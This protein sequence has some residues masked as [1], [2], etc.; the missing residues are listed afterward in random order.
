LE[1]ALALLGCNSPADVSAAHVARAASG[2][3]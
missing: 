1:L 2:L 3:T